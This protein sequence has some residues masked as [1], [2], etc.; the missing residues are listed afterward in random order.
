MD[1][2]KAQAA[3]RT[4]QQAEP[5]RKARGGAA[6][7][8]RPRDQGG[9]F[10]IVGIGASAG[11][12]E[13][14][15]QFLRHVSVESGMAFVVV[16]HLDPTHKGML[17]ELLQ[18]ATSMKVIQIK[19]RLKVE[20]DRVYVI[21]PNQDLSILHGVLYLLAPMAPRGLRLPIDFFLRSLAD[22]QRDRSIGVILSGM[23][24]DGTLGVRAIKEQAGV[25]FVQAL[26]SAKF[27]AMPR[28]VIDAGLADVVAPVEDLPG[29]IAAYLAHGP[30][31]K[32]HDQP[33]PGKTQ[34]AV[35]KVC[36]LLRSQT[37][38]D[39][40]LYKRSTVYRRIERRMGLHQL[41]SIA[42]YLRYLQE[43]PQEIQLLFKELLIGVTNFFR[44]PAAWELLCTKV[45]PEILAAH[46]AGGTL[47]AW[48]PG[49][50][51]GEEAYSLA[52]I[53]KEVVEREK[54]ARNFTLQIFATDLD[55][56]AI[57]RAR[58]GFY[59]ANIASDVSAERLRRFFVEDKHGYQVA[60]QIRQTVI[61]APQNLIMDP[62]FTR[63]DIL[64]CRNLLIYLS[65]ELQKKL[66]PLFHYSLT[67]GGIL[68]LGSA[69]TVGAATALFALIDGK[70]RIYRRLDG[71]LR[72]EPL[73]FPIS[74]S[75]VRLPGAEL[76]EETAAH[77]IAPNLQLLSEQLLLQRYVPAAVLTND[78]G[79]ILY[80][81]GRIGKYLEPAA[82]KANWNVYAMA[83]EGLRYDLSAAFAKAVREKRTVT[84]AGVKVE[85]GG[86]AQVVDVVI[87]PIQEPEGLRGTVMVVFTD[88]AA[89]EAKP[90]GKL[91]QTGTS[92][93]ALARMEQELR[94]A[95]DELQTTR[96]QMQ[97]S[98]EELRS[99][100]EEMQ[101]A[102]EEL[103][104]TNEELTT[105]KEE[106]QSMNEEL[107][108]LN[109]ELQSKV[110]DLSRV[111][112][113]MKNLLDST[114]IATLFL[115][116]TLN[117][118]RFTPEVLKII[119]LIPGDQGRP[120]TDLASDLVYPE[121]ADDAR[122]V[123]RSLVFKEKAIATCDGR[124]FTV[125]TMPYRTLDNRIDGVVITFLDITAAKTLEASLR[126]TGAGA[127]AGG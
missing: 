52:M 123:L 50:S 67:P 63:L 93:A 88:V 105:S 38:N 9:S 31:V 26:A 60:K 89:P 20:P 98:Q 59:P 77:K 101:S 79:D 64:S 84:R 65:P 110:E 114:D 49:C 33:L 23:G 10:P 75:P 87:E 13:A 48:V 30:V 85:T 125:R 70:A 74:A 103:Q 96:E 102:N 82:G 17:V 71:A 21:P 4:R 76:V 55:K 113:D 8:S 58:Q 45:L 29:K 107:Q 19:D 57:E 72:A 100:N 116:D 5:A 118:R 35:E 97:T 44:D 54:P 47:R 106:M 115:D 121:L 22:D 61:F 27:D 24:S 126:G 69:E 40:S 32:L 34:S 122:E 124:W 127:E 46:P 83:R 28:S 112:N 120:I 78:K 80:I 15:E 39:F 108:T 104:S 94:Q 12:L 18:R 36:V 6:V 7:A 14:I 81:S 2:S 66:M 117:V 56:D 25:V 16:Q 51:T 43:S 11:G 3:K 73:A 1:R 86:G 95:R 37:G 68:L 99:A 111:N 42:D 109:Q 119:K 90:P 41:D 92:P 53:F 91:R 62:P